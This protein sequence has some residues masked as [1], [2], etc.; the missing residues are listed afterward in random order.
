M[1]VKGT[2][3]LILFMILH[4]GFILLGKEA[5]MTKGRCLFI[6]VEV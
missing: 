5:F 6:K 1:A 2:M 4:W 3:Q